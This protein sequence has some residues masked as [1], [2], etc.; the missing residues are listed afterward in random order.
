MKLTNS[1]W[2]MLR[3]LSDDIKLRLAS[4][5]TSS[6]ADNR[7]KALTSNKDITEQM[8]EKYA[9]ALTDDR[10]SDEINRSIYSMR[11]SKTIQDFSL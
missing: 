5:L 2:E 8:I 9:G 3:F 1:Y 11:S 4:L 6:V 7:E 10:S